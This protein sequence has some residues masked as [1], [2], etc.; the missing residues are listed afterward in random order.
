MKTVAEKK[1]K[2]CECYDRKKCQEWNH[3]RGGDPISISS[4]RCDSAIEYQQQLLM[5]A[6]GLAGLPVCTGFCAQTNK[7]Q[8][9]GA[10][11]ISPALP[12]ARHQAPGAPPQTHWQGAAADWSRI[13]A[14]VSNRQHTYGVGSASMCLWRYICA[15]AGRP[16]LKGTWVITSILWSEAG[17]EAATLRSP[18]KVSTEGA[19]A[20]Q[21]LNMKVSWVRFEE[22]KNH[23]I[24][25][26]GH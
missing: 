26:N 2:F 16:L 18:S 20:A 15:G 7:P 5:R 19:G 14:S 9:A 6:R 11:H 24:W 17:H 13:Y 23:L 25:V 12:L 4:Y 10:T 22:K 1:E 8:A 21:W 3:E